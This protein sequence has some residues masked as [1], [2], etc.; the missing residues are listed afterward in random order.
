M[1]YIVMAN[2]PWPDGVGC[3]RRI[4]PVTALLFIDGP[5]VYVFIIHRWPLRVCVDYLLLFVYR[6]GAMAQVLRC[7]LRLVA[8][9]RLDFLQ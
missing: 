6:L 1:A 4:G 8:A 7:G 3:R 5:W 2:R 9:A